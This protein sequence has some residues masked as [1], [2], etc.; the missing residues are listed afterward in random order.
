MVIGDEEGE[1]AD[2]DE[3]D[4]GVEREEPGTRRMESD[5]EDDD[6]AMEARRERL[7]MLARQRR[8]MEVVEQ[9]PTSVL[10]HRC[11]AKRTSMSPTL[12][13]FLHRVKLH[14]SS[15]KDLLCL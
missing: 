14:R 6:D 5:D 9:V 11:L 13:H 2:I 12:H 1:V 3:R 10:M 4:Y 7:R 8:A 15:R